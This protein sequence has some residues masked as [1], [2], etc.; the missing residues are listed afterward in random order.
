MKK[1]MNINH[2]MKAVAAMAFAAVSFV[3]SAQ[4]YPG[5]I[6]DK[7]IA[8]VG[9]EII[10]IADLEEEV[11]M[12]QA[13]GMKSD[14]NVRCEVLEDMMA[15]R[16]F[17]MQARVDSLAVNNDMVRATSATVSTTSGLISAVMKEWRKSSASRSTSFVRN[18][19]RR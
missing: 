1:V 16:L 14:K 11:Q 18:G 15:S 7:T 10:T 4:K 12:M 9:N 13:Y 6:I 2:I 17:L 19:A 8:V 3:A 5:G